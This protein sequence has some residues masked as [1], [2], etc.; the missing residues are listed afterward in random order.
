MSTATQEWCE[1]RV[2]ARTLFIHAVLQLIHGTAEGKR[3]AGAWA[4][5]LEREQTETSDPEIRRAEPRAGSGVR[6]VE[7]VRE[8]C[9]RMAE[10]KG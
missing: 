3:A 6:L 2:E 5:I 10:S 1:A 8:L 9:S 4:R 7:R